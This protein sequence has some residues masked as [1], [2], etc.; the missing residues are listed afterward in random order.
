VS[1]PVSRADASPNVVLLVTDNQS[2]DSLG[3]YGNVDHETPRLD[4]LAR[5]GVLF[6]RAFCTNGLCSP[7]RASILTGLMP[8]QHGV[9]LAIPDDSVLP[10]PADYDV[11]REFPSIAQTLRDHGYATAMIGKWHLGNH[12]QPGH[13]FDHWE[14]LTSGHT[15]DF[16]SNEVYCDGRVEEVTGRHIVDDIA[17]RA[18][19]YLSSRAQGQPFFLMV[20]FDGPYVLPPTVV[21]ADERNP[22]YERFARQAFRPFPAIDERLIASLAV[23]FDFGLDPTEEYTLASAFNNVW[24]ALRS[25]NDPATRANVAAQNALVDHAVGRVVDA[26]DDQG[27]GADTL[28]IATTDQGNPFGQ[29]GLWGHP[30]WTDPPFMHDVTFRVPLLMRRPGTVVAQRVVDRVVSHVDLFPT[31]VDHVGLGEEVALNGPG[32]SLEPALHGLAL[33]RATDVAFFEN[34]TARSVRTLEHLYTRH[35]DGTGPPELYDLVDDPEQWH[36]VADDPRRGGLLA[37]LDDQLRAF[38]AECSDRRYD[39]WNGGTG[40]AMVSRYLLF[41]SRYGPDWEPTMEVGPPFAG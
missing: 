12:R 28:V 22:F 3:C 39:L 27:L 34:E 38:F 2:A 13:G 40:Q 36:N 18:V 10:K 24:W 6:L 9:H 11:T 41:K 35:L 20:N 32:S 19:A 4:R 8:S 15:T 26:L 23:P 37:Y 33:D 1:S 17:D 25:H 14:A 16:Y 31:V 30:I 7:S 29:R 21:G 5:E